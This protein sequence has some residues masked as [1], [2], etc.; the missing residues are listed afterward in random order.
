VITRYRHTRRKVD[1]ERTDLIFKRA[2]RGLRVPLISVCVDSCLLVLALAVSACVPK[3]PPAPVA[4]TKAPPAPVI[5]IDRKAGWILRLEQARVLEDAALGADLAVLSRDPEAGVRRRAVLAV[6]RVGIAA[7][8]PIAAAALADPEENVRATAAFALGLLADAEGVPALLAALK[9]ASPLVRGRA[10]EGLGLIGAPA[11]SAGS[12]IADAASG[13]ASVIAAIPPDDEDAKGPDA[14][15]CRLSIVALVRLRQFDALSRVVLDANGAPVSR[16]WPVAFGLQ[17]SG[18]A[19]AAGPLATLASGPG[20]YTPAFAIRGLAA[21]N[22]SRT[23]S[24]AAPLAAR[25]DADVRLRAES[26]RAL[27][28]VAARETLPMLAGL[29]EDRNTPPGLVLEAITAIGAIA[30]PRAFEVMLD[31]FSS[32]SPIVRSAAMTAAAR[33]DGDGFLIALSSLERDK[34]W[35]V[36]ANLATILSRL[37]A[38]KAR[39][40]LEDL[41]HDADVRVQVPALQALVRL[42]G[43]DVDQRILQALQAPDFGLRGA[44]AALVGERRPAGG[45]AALAEAYV[46]GESDST[47]SAR[48]A[49]IEALAKYPP[50]E[51]R[52]TLTKALGDLEWS[53]RL[54]AARLLREGGVADASPVRP[55]RF[56]QDAAIFESE[57]LLHPAYT[58]HAYI[59]TRAGTIQI[60]LNM[61]DA[62]FTTLAFIELARS[63]FFNG[64]KVH[65]LIPNFVIQA[66]DPRGDGEGGPGY[67]IRDELSPLPF[68]RGTVGMALGGKETGGSQFFITLSP[69][70]HLDGLY[71]VFGR[72]VGGWE[73]LDQVALGDVIERVLIRDGAER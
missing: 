54:V 6:G 3:T 43:N 27:G 40:A 29:V 34:D 47:Y 56:R 65:R 8:V 53:V 30:D 45:A 71:A 5:P 48:V 36:R 66:G 49:S 1:T 64:L 68:V 12:A 73:V 38:D 59:Q 62:P 52:E 51:A 20:V 63:G 67:S 13:C 7:G 23:A 46:R 15:A 60:E 57:R 61:V 35:S 70:P 32:P 50:A 19:K 21:L 44:A 58:P 69:Q 9:D 11:A 24:L 26:I 14:D 17:R 33:L 72:V 4:V 2:P 41:L 37:P 25:A 28:R 10:A 55:A 39:P 16:W 18:D 22:D 42:G 31:R